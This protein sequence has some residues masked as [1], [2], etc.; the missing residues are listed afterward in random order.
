[1]ATLFKA[2]PETIAN[3][4]RSGELPGTKMGK[5]WVFLRGDV[6]AFLRQRIAQETQR[7]RGGSEEKSLDTK[8]EGII[9]PRKKRVRRTTL[10]ALPQSETPFASP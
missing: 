5:S 9:M 6:I 2:E 1:V 3:Y 4:A 10:P 7:R 8:P